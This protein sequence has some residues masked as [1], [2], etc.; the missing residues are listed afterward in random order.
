MPHKV[1]I[2]YKPEKDDPNPAAVNHTFQTLDGAMDFVRRQQQKPLV[3]SA[4]YLG[5]VA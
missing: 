3:E 5:E 1:T 4:Q 2:T